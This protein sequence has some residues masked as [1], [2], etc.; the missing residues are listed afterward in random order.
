MIILGL[1]GQHL[2]PL[3]S[4]ACVVLLTSPS[5]TFFTLLH[6]VPEWLPHCWLSQ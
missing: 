3:L 4:L 5:L 6:H 2:C 1:I